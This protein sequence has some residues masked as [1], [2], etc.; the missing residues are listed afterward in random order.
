MTKFIRW[1]RPVAID[2]IEWRL[3]HRFS[4]FYRGHHSG[5]HQFQAWYTDIKSGPFARALKLQYRCSDPVLLALLQQF[6]QM[7]CTQADVEILNSRVMEKLDEDELV[8]YQ[9]AKVGFQRYV[10]L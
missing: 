1:I 2:S 5:L 10:Y 3:A 8:Q 9:Q 4:T 6:R 7:S